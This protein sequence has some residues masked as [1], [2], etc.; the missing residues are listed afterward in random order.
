MIIETIIDRLQ[1]K[2][3]AVL[4]M[5]TKMNL[6]TIFEIIKMTTR[7]HHLKDYH[8]YLVILKL[9]SQKVNMINENNLNY[10]IYPIFYLFLN[11]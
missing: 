11:S 8:K 7:D 5:I 4:W 10:L 9:V 3:L 2:K 1:I 6:Q